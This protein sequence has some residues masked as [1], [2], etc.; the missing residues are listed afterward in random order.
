ME[1]AMELEGYFDFL[2]PL[3]IR[4]KGHRI[5]IDDVLHYYLRGY[6]PEAIQ[7]RYPSLNLEEIEAA[8][9]YYHD[10]QPQM[11]Q[12]LRALEAW[13]EQLYQQIEANP[14]PAAQRIRNALQA[15]R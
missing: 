8:I 6:T 2:D 3:D 10:N 12:Y 14:P 9:A 4:I 7:E 15:K 13:Q 11:D 5:G 1:A